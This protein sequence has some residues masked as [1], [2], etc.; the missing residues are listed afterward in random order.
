VERRR[1]KALGNSIAPPI[2]EAI[3]NAILASLAEKKEAA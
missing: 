2:P 3:G 1:V